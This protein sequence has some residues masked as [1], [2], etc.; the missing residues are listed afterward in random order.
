MFKYTFD[1]A[2]LLMDNTDLSFKKYKWNE[3]LEYVLYRLNNSIGKKWDEVEKQ[4]HF[5]KID[6]SKLSKS[7]LS[8]ANG[9]SVY[10]LALNN[11]SRVFGLKINDIF[12]IIA[13]D[14]N[15]QTYK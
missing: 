5:H 3:I 7:V 10:Q 11:K 9:E 8:R 14:K 6:N 2:I 15:H 12:Y 13:Y 1:R 4:N